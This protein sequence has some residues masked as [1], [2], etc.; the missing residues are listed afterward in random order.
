MLPGTSGVVLREEAL[1]DRVEGGG[2]FQLGSERVTCKEFWAFGG[3]LF[4]FEAL[5]VNNQFHF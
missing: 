1:H 5:C 4:I 3:K 2:A